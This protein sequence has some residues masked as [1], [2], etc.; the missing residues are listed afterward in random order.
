MGVA[1]SN[2]PGMPTAMTSRFRRLLM[3]VALLAVFAGLWFLPLA[4]MLDSAARWSEAHPVASPILYLG[5]FPVCVV[6]LVPASW[7]AMFAGYV[8]GL[9]EGIVLASAGASIGAYAA[10]CNGRTLARPIVAKRLAE[11][12]NL[13]A[14]DH[15][16][17]DKSFAVVFLTRIALLIPY[18]LL[19]YL[20]SLTSI[21][22][23]PY[24]LPSVLGIIPA[25][26]LFVFL[27][28]QARSIEE[29]LSGNLGQGRIGL[30]ILAVS[31][32]AVLLVAVLLQRA[33]KKALREALDD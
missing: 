2:L 18:N 24:L 13:A 27:G 17:A 31:S 11:N 28:T 21:R 26:S 15:A 23:L 5:I 3:A 29:I 1:T 4:G 25:M 33:A 32:V 19:N 9:G 14:L 22:H 20:Y 16:L 6:L 12:P 10:F 30:L 8:F 7:I